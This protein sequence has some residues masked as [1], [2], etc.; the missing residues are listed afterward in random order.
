VA[1]PTQAGDRHAHRSSE[2]RARVLELERR[3][4][5]LLALDDERF[6]G[7]GVGDWIA[8]VC[9]ALIVPAAVLLWFA[10]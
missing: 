2:E 4:E 8:C 9:F 10:R 1:P 7:F 6:G 5:E 3:I